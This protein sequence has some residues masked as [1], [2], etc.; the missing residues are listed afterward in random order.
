MEREKTLRRRIRATTWFFI[1]GLAI[2]GVTAIPLQTEVDWLVEAM[3][4]QKVIEQSS[5]FAQVAAGWLLKVQAALHQTGTERPFLFYGTDWLA[6]GHFVIAIAFVGALRD[7]VRNSWLFTFGLIACALVLP[8]ALLF[9][10][11]RGIPIWWRF[12][13]CAFGVLGAIPLWL[14]KRWT[15]ELE[16]STVSPSQPLPNLS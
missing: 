8:Y 16:A 10:A 6:F 15:L 1:F 2:S 5:G 11:I 12:I 3:G 7:P 4:G 14:C 9:G 13:D